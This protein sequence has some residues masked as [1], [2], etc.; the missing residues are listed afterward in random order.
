MKIFASSLQL[1]LIL[2]YIT[3]YSNFFIQVI[4]FRLSIFIYYIT[5]FGAFLYS[6]GFFSE[7]H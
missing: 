7:N 1:C 5:T 6:K 2:I 3:I 4:V